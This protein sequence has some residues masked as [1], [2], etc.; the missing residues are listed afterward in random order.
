MDTDPKLNAAA[1]IQRWARMPI[2]RAD[3]SSADW[4]AYSGT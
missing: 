2:M 3:I 1:F 4:N